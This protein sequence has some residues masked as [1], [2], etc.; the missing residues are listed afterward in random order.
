MKLTWARLEQIR[1]NHPDAWIKIDIR[2]TDADFPIPVGAAPAAYVWPD[3]KTAAAG[4]E[5][6]CL[7]IYWLREDD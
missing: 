5:S 2:K 4:D 3:R 7:A 6:R 1:K